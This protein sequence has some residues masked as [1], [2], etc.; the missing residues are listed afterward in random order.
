MK[1]EDSYVTGTI[2]FPHDKENL[3]SILDGF[4]IKSSVG[5]W[6]LRLDD[7]PSSFKICYVGNIT[8]SEPYEVEVDGY[9]VATAVVADWCKRVAT[10]LSEHSITYEITHFDS[11]GEEICV[12]NA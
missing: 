12:Y 6:A 1:P 3:A 8:P 7:Y 4:G 9:N 10:C 2:F 5:E 11:D